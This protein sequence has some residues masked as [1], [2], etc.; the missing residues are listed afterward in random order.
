MPLEYTILHTN[1]FHNKL[2]EPQAERLRGLRSAI[3]DRGL[4]LD[5]GDAIGS[6]NI[7]FRPGGEP[8]L[9]TLSDIGYSAMTVGNREFHFSRIGMHSK[10][11]RARF[12]VLCANV[13]LNSKTPPDDN[14]FSRG[15]RADPPVSP[16][17]LFELEGG[18][19][20]VVFGVTVPMITEKMSVKHV[21]AYLF[22]EPVQTALRLA[23]Q[24]KETLRPDLIVALTHIGAR[25]DRVLAEKSNSI[26]LIIGGHSHVIMPLGEW[27]GETLVVQAGSHG[28][29]FGTVQV[30]PSATGKERFKARV[31]EL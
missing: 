6:G 2:S 27:F 21:S 18:Y 11:S 7:T 23:D 15:R 19:R 31:E 10:V 26:D 17:N 22:D 28:R 24:L 29:L 13:R 9:D 4:L 5:A 16:W 14:D 30:S 25:L 20:V 12:P 3:G 8:I 1:D